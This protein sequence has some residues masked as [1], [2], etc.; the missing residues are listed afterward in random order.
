[1]SL[2]QL[3]VGVAIVLLLA[4]V[5]AN[6]RMPDSDAHSR[7]LEDLSDIR[8]LDAELNATVI[9]LRYG[10]ANNYDPLVLTINALRQRER[11]LARG[12]FAAATAK[13]GDL[14]REFAAL[15]QTLAARESLVEE[16]KF[17]NAVLKNSF[18][19]F[20]RAI[21]SLLGDARIAP[22]LGARLQRL[23]NEILLLPFDATPDRY[24]RVAK[25]IDDVAPEQFPPALRPR[26]QSTAN[27]A[28]NI[29]LYQ[30]R[31]DAILRKLVCTEPARC[32]LQSISATAVIVRTAWLCGLLVLADAASRTAPGAERAFSRYADRDAR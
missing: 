7:F 20:P 12:E 31:V 5:F 15:G 25:L 16:F 22:A 1:M 6:A 18:L 24:E 3:P 4:L 19:Y 10:L 27:H 28:R 21:Q 14:A 9:R 8:R 26:A 29:V 32:Q 2:R 13:D 17:E 11:D 23:L 30:Q